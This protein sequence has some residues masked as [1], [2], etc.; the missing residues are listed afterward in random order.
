MGTDMSCHIEYRQH[1]RWIGFG[2]RFTPR[3]D[4]VLFPLLANVRGTGAPYPP[5]GIPR[6]ADTP[7]RD[8]YCLRVFDSAETEMAWHVRGGKGL[9]ATRAEADQYVARGLSDWWDET[10][11]CVT[12]PEYKGGSW[13]TTAEWR[14]VLERYDAQVPAYLAEQRA[15]QQEALAGTTEPWRRKTLAAQDW[16]A[17]KAANWLDPECRMLLAAME[18]GEARGLPVRCVFWFAG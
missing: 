15:R 4:Y 11:Q 16:G 2:G 1:D 17:H 14:A 6:D 8:D 13:L 7:V 9:S 18:A 5:R 10:R 12:N 3:R